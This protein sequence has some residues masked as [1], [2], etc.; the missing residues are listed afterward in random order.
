MEWWGWLCCASVFC[1]RK[2]PMPC[3]VSLLSEQGLRFFFFSLEGPGLEESGRKWLLWPLLLLRH[4]KHRSSGQNGPS[5]PLGSRKAGPLCCRGSCPCWPLPPCGK[6]SPRWSLVLLLKAPWCGGLIL[7]QH[8]LGGDGFLLCVHM[9]MCQCN[10]VITAVLPRPE[11]LWEPDWPWHQTMRNTSDFVNTW[12]YPSHFC[13]GFPFHSALREQRRPLLVCFYK[14]TE[15]V[16]VTWMFSVELF[17]I[18]F[19]DEVL[20]RRD[21]AGLAAREANPSVVLKL[22]N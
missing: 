3:S 19:P 17:M 8:R 11:I 15:M 20:Q 2:K 1:E 7:P 5:L 14:K 18:R 22:Q 21:V 6:S 10:G 4:L 13:L 9:E 12:L 16:G